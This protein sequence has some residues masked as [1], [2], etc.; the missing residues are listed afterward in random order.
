MTL[1]IAWLQHFS[2]GKS[3]VGAIRI[4]SHCDQ[5]VFEKVVVFIKEVSINSNNQGRILSFQRT[6][7]ALPSPTP[8]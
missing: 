7:L 6:V 2:R 1:C 4:Y 8:T 5:D 3:L